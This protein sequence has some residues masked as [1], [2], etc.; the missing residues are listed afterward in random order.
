MSSPTRIRVSYLIRC[1]KRGISRRGFLSGVLTFGAGTFVM[2]TSSLVS[3]AEAATSRFAFEQV[4]ASTADTITVPDGYEWDVAIQWGDQL[5]SNTPAFD[6]TTRGDAASQA[7]AFGDN[8]DGMT[9][10]KPKQM[11][12]C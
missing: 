2:G 7:L 6:E 1:L 3:T 12:M 9:L 5:F 4:A 10:F 11:M 8:N